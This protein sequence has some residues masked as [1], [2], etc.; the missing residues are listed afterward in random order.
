M[1][2]DVFVQDPS[3]SYRQAVTSLGRACNVGF[4]GDLSYANVVKHKQGYVAS[5]S[6]TPTGADDEFF[7][8]YNGSS[9]DIII[10]RIVLVDAAAETIKLAVC[11]GTP[12]GGTTLTSANLYSGSTNTTAGKSATIE[13]GVDITGLT[14]G[15]VLDQFATG[16][17]TTIER[18]YDPSPVVVPPGIAVCLSAVTGTS[19]ITAL[20][21]FEYA[22]EPVI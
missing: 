4:T 14:L 20:V 12:A 15:A 3:N 16:V 21:Y 19:A 10:R 18:K 6:R 22:M 2:T 8:M 11:T 7:Y 17:G 5:I 9:D 13:S 1:S